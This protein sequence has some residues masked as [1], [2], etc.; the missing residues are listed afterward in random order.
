MVSKSYRTNFRIFFLNR[1]IACFGFLV[2][3]PFEIAKNHIHGLKNLKE[4]KRIIFILT[5]RIGESGFLR[6]LYI[7]F[8]L[9]LLG[10]ILELVFQ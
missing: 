9:V 1:F 8:C 2:V 3:W 7:G 4:S 5:K 6:G 10:Y